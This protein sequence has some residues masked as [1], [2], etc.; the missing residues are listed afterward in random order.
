MFNFNMF[1]YLVDANS[2][3]TNDEGRQLLLR[4]SETKDRLDR[5]N[6]DS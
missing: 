4:V 5:I 6:G 2:L 3:F 1:I